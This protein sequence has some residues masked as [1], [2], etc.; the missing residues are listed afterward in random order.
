MNTVYILKT[1]LIFIWTRKTLSV[2]A[3]PMGFDEMQPD[4]MKTPTLYLHGDHVINYWADEDGYIVVQNIDGWYVYADASETGVDLLP[5]D[6]VFGIDHPDKSS[7]M[8]HNIPPNRKLREGDINY[9]QSEGKRSGVRGN[10]ANKVNDKR[11]LYNTLDEV[12]LGDGSTV[13]KNLVVLMRFKDHTDRMLPSIHDIDILMNHDGALS[14]IPTGSVSDV[15]KRNSFGKFKIQSDI[16]EWVTISRTEAECADGANGYTDELVHCMREALDILSSRGIRFSD[17]DENGDGEF[18]GIM[19]LHSGYGAEFGSSD[20]HGQHYRSRIWSHK[21]TMPTRLHWS[22]SNIHDNVTFNKYHISGATWGKCGSKIARIGAIAH[23]TGHFLGLPDLYDTDGSGYGVGNYD[24]MANMWGWRNDQYYPP[25]MSCWTKMQL[26]W[27]EPT[28]VDVSG[29]YE[30]PAAASS[31]SCLKISEGFPSGEYLLI[32]NRYAM[33]Y[34]NFMPNG[35]G[36]AVWH[37]DEA[38]GLNN[39][40]H[41]GQDN[42]PENNKHYKVS[43]VQA[44]GL[45]H[46]EQKENR[47]DDGD[48]F[49]NGDE[50]F[51]FESHPNSMSY[52]GGNV[53]TTNIHIFDISEPGEVM[54]FVVSFGDLNGENNQATNLTTSV[55]N[56]IYTGT[57]GSLNQT[58]GTYISSESNSNIDANATVNQ[59]IPTT[60][61]PVENLTTEETLSTCEDVPGFFLKIESFT[62]EFLATINK[63]HRCSGGI[64]IEDNCKRSCGLCP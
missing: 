33:S 35:G 41:P 14:T 50:F 38:A 15:Y 5:T 1:F 30:L 31:P 3:Y 37:I 39:E 4:G 34:D 16:Q 22:S 7:L 60:S 42:W 10:R 49:R 56:T 20:C 11:S 13:M 2:P 52:Q 54:S 21:W 57:D 44:D 6:L 61:E 29:T 24:L 25:L 51:P 59:I 62:C 47:G 17:W 45:F 28:A 27:I 53:S 8:K 55:S 18:D 32:E 36:L 23:E 46:L 58:N 64:C 40:G 43:L 19:F 26:G 63:C 48:S 9:I 12:S